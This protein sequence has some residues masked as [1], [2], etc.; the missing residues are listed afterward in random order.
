MGV[1]EGVV[2]AVRVG[3]EDLGEILGPPRYESESAMHSG[4]PGQD[5]EQLDVH[6]HVPT[7]AT[8][9]DG[10]SAGITRVL[11]P[12]RN[13][14]ELDEIPPAARKRLQII[15]IEQVH[16]ALSAVLKYGDDD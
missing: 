4:V 8:P 13:R 14:K 10:P 5:F 1:A 2:E 3:S 15:W 7:G 9:K 16:E 12:A 11:L 6:M